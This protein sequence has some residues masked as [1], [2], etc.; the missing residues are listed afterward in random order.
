MIRDIFYVGIMKAAIK[1]L[2][3]LQI[4]EQITAD[5]N[6][7]CQ[8]F[9]SFCSFCQKN[10]IASC[11][12][13][14]DSF[15]NWKLLSLWIADRWSLW[16]LYYC[17]YI[18]EVKWTVYTFSHSTKRWSVI[19]ILWIVTV[20]VCCSYTA[21]FCSVDSLFSLYYKTFK[22]LTLSLSKGVNRYCFALVCVFVYL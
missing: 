17:A 3:D 15:W 9:K 6:T 12:M 10:S 13:G 2:I 21:Y 19:Y 22:F 1:Q 11:I 4:S 18:I 20:S 16:F 8:Q 14:V 7:A 5:C